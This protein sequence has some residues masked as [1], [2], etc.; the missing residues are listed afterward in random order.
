MG[1]GGM[2]KGEN[3]LKPQVARALNNLAWMLATCQ[4]SAKAYR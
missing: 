3:D 4:D 1:L 2:G